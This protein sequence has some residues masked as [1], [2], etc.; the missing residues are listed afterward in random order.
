MRRCTEPQPA[1]I[2]SSNG[3][4]EPTRTTSDGFTLDMEV[5]DQMPDVETNEAI[6]AS[7][8]MDTDASN[9]NNANN[10]TTTVKKDQDLLHE[11]ILYG[12][13]LQAD[14]PGDEKKEHK[15]TLDD[16]FSLVAYAD[17]KTSVHGHLLD[18][19]GR[20]AVAEEL[21]SAILGNSPLHLFPTT[22]TNRL[23]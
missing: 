19:S 12:Q 9:I 15:K 11:A 13:Q 4:S 7:D 18:P 21:N 6:A 20:V 8:M 1:A 16:I 3:L 17:P 14:Y 5:D 23:P 22:S 10:D 2:S